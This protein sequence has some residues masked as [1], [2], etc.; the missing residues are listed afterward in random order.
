MSQL[1]HYSHTTSGSRLC[2]GVCV[3]VCHAGQRSGNVRSSFCVNTAIKT[4]GE[5]EIE[6]S[7][8]VGERETEETAG[9]TNDA[10]SG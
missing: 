1:R 6:R 5:R 9:G 2:T 8:R 3:C 10:Q 4:Q 7:E